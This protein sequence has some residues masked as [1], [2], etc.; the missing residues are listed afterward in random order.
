MIRAL[1]GEKFLGKKIKY[2]EQVEFRGTAYAI[3]LCRAELAGEKKFL[4]MYADDFHSKKAIAKCLLYDAALL[5]FPVEDPRRFGVVIKHQDGTVKRIDEKPENP[6]SNLA[7]TGVYVLTPKI[8]DYY[9]DRPRTGEYYLTEMIEGFVHDYPLYAVVSDF[10][11]PIA[12]PG[13]ITYAESILAG[14]Q[15]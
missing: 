13:D 12:Y 5:V 15:L 3:N 6:Q 1:L 7:A 2:I 4:V 8:F 9:D 11:I 14:T 10:W